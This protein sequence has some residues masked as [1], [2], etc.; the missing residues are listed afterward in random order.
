VDW[1]SADIGEYSGSLWN[2]AAGAEYQ[3]SKNFGLSLAYQFFR[4]DVDVD[5]GNWK[6]A[7]EVSFEGPFVSVTA[8]W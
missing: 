2:A 7:V 8:T 4:I 1:F 3:L 5:S 6:G